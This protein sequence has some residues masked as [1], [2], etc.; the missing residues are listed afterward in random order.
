M[1]ETVGILGIVR[2]VSESLIKTIEDI[3]PAAPCCY[4]EQSCGIFVNGGDVIMTDAAGRFGVRSV[5][6]EKTTVQK[7]LR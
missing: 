2:V 5:S 7:S 1:T 4:P 6:E 3:N